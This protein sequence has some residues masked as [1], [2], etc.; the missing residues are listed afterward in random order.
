MKF[1]RTEINRRSHIEMS[2]K[3]IL[4]NLNSFFTAKNRSNQ[5]KKLNKQKLW[6]NSTNFS[7]TYSFKLDF[8]VIEHRI[9]H[10]KWKNL[11]IRIFCLRKNG[12]FICH[13]R[14]QPL[15]FHFAIWKTV[16]YW[17]SLLIHWE[18]SYRWCCSSTKLFFLSLLL[19]IN[20]LCS[21]FRINQSKQTNLKSFHFF[22]SDRHRNIG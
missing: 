12:F 3:F 11:I 19:F 16:P 20:V 13:K 5:W 10:L 8:Y 15:Y 7:S 18:I 6:C 14:M 2:S 22:P 17:P 21:K 4:D 9:W 1:I